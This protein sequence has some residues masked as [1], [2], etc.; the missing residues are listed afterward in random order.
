ME[1]ILQTNI[2]MGGVVLHVLDFQYLVFKVLYFSFITQLLR[3]LPQACF[4]LLPF[5]SSEYTLLL[6]SI[7]FYLYQYNVLCCPIGIIVVLLQS[8]H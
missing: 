2:K 4:L 7:N 6:Y 3:S 5:V 8:S 1:F